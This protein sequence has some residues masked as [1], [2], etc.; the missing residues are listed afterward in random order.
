MKIHFI[1][2]TLNEKTGGGSH[3]NALAYIRYLQMHG[4]DV[5]VHAFSAHGTEAPHDVPVTLHSFE[6]LSFQKAHQALA[7]LLPALEKDAD[8]F[9][10][11]GVDF[12]WGGGLYRQNGGTGPVSVYLDTYLPTMRMGSVDSTGYVDRG[13]YLLKRFLWESTIGRTYREHIDRFIAVSPYLHDVYVRFGFNSK[14]F[15][16]LPNAFTLPGAPRGSPGLN[17]V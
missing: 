3:H 11:Y 10:L 13:T 7:N 1:L 6:S 16:I 17:E 2:R 5:T 9:F 4:H 14:K 8:V 15:S 12:L